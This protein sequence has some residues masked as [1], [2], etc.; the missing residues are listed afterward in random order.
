[1]ALNKYKNYSGPVSLEEENEANFF[2]LEER[3]FWGTK[4]FVGGIKKIYERTV[5]P[6]HLFAYQLNITL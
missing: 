4:K 2:L 6:D 1:M 3:N 5:K